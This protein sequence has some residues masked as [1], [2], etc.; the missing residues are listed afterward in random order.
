MSIERWD[1]L[2]EIG[3]IHAEVDRLF[4]NFLKQIPSPIIEEKLTTWTPLVNIYDNRENIIIEVALPGVKKEDIDL[5]LQDR[6]LTISGVRIGKSDKP[7]YQQEWR[8][9]NFEREIEIPVSIKTESI[10]AEYT[11]GI[12]F[13]SIQKDRGVI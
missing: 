1:I 6:I 11:D 10:I 3:A 2:K 7:H 12:L 9:G 5:S 8:Y 4:T 13:I